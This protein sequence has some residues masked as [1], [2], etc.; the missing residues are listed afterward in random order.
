MQAANSRHGRAARM[1]AIA[2]AALSL[3]GADPCVAQQRPKAKQAPPEIDFAQFGRPAGPVTG[4]IECDQWSCGVKDLGLYGEIRPLMAA[5]LNNLMKD[6]RQDAMSK[7][8]IIAAGLVVTISSDGGSIKAA[9]EI[10]RLLRNER[11]TILVRERTH[12]NSACVL[13]IAGAVTRLIDAPIGIHR[14]YLEVPQ[15]EQRPEVIASAYKATLQGVR[16]YLVEMN[17]SERLAEA[18]FTIEPSDVRFLSADAAASYGLGMFDP[19]NKEV[20][21]LE[22]ARSLGINRQEYLRRES[23]MGKI[24]IRASDLPGCVRRVMETGR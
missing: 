16:D 1:L 18:M 24:C 7:R 11:A 8:K 15:Q 2:L 14:P 4:S 20:Q 21:D 19:I 12:C 23:L 6:L 22:H 5:D 3:V 13:V 9:M 10:G 17:V